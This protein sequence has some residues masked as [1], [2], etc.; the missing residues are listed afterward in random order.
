MRLSAPYA[1][2]AL[3]VWAL[4]TFGHWTVELWTR[5]YFA[6]AS[7]AGAL[8]PEGGTAGFIRAEWLLAAVFGLCLALPAWRMARLLHRAPPADRSRALAPWLVWA[9]AAWLCWHV[10][11]VYTTELVHFVQYALIG[12][13]CALA[14]DRGRRPQ[15]AF[16]LAVALGVLDEIWQH[17][18][19]NTWQN[20]SPYHR[21]DWSDFVLNSVGSAAGVLP[22]ATRLRLD[23]APPAEGRLVPKAVLLAA[24]ALLPLLLLEPA[25]LGRWMGYYPYYPFWNEYT[26]HKPV[27]WPTPEEGIPLFIGALY[28]LGSLVRPGKP[29]Y[30]MV[31][32]A[33]LGVLFALGV[34]PPRRGVPQPVHA[35]VP[36]ARVPHLGADT[37]AV[38]GRLSEK[39]WER[40]LR[41]GPF[42]DSYTGGPT[43]PPTTARLLW[44][45]NALYVAF[46]AVDDDLWSYRKHEDRMLLDEGVYVL[47]DE[48]GDEI[49]HIALYLR[50]DGKLADAYYFVA[51]PPLDYSPWN[52]AIGLEAWDAEGVRAAVSLDGTLDRVDYW[53]SLP[54][55]DTDGGYRAEIEIPWEVFRTTSTPSSGARRQRPHPRP[56]DR[57]R[58]NLHRVDRPRVRLEALEAQGRVD[59]AAA[60]AGLGLSRAEF[61]R[62]LGDDRLKPADADTA[63]ITGKT[64]LWQLA[65]EERRLQAWAVPYGDQLHFPPRFGVIEF[66]APDE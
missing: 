30:P 55:S 13:L 48:G 5:S 59:T 40:A 45:E 1:A 42:V 57:W 17:Y 54:A 3:A 47:F 4:L 2:A 53:N 15:A 20:F 24:V 66:A 7:A 36:R 32:V 43:A 19:I 34:Q 41:L 28:V 44:D 46:D 31:G 23:G 65:S 18:G 35:E 33:A 9:V 25:T 27:H 62:R 61:E 11:I 51:A 56:G 60:R 49:S 12:A 50:T 39:A 63:Y 29:A 10:Y 26:N 22:F 64:Y 37:I 6:W 52:R 8:H 14:L 16:L 58:L 21:L 38:D